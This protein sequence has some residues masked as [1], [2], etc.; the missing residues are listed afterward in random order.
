MARFE[1]KHTVLY[2]HGLVLGHFKLNQSYY[3]EKF[4][5]LNRAGRNG[6][7]WVFFFLAPVSE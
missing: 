7:E 6:N 2:Q 3:L 1:L 5:L 4:P